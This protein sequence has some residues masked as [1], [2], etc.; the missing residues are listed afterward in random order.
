[1]LSFCILI[2]A[3]CN[4]E[5][6]IDDFLPE[7]PSIVIEE[8]GGRAGITFESDNWDIIYIGE[9]GI[10]EHFIQNEIRDL[11]GNL[12]QEYLP[13]EGYKLASVSCK[14]EFADFCVKREEPCSLE[15]S[16]GENMY[17]DPLNIQIIV[18]N[19]YE[20]KSISV[21]LGASARYRIDSVS[22]E[23]SGFHWYDNTLEPVD[24][25]TINNSSSAEPVTWIVYPY[26]DAHR[27]IEFRGNE[28]ENYGRWLGE[29]LPEIEI[30]DISDGKPVLA[31]TKAV[32]GMMDQELKTDLPEDLSEEVIIAPG[33]K[34]KVTVFLEM[35]IY[36]VPYKV[37][38]SSPA[39]GRKKV[40]SG[41]LYSDR[42]FGHFIL[43]QAADD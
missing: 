39:T 40:F 6:F 38:A 16:L 41:K 28:I 37:Y 5:A 24:E 34:R 11:D 10:G 12:L 30:P 4:T 14:T 23:F 32:F 15:V 3:G 19:G 43:K 2:L 29:S 20:T 22:Y 21:K 25:L 8:G 31:G 26:K 33:E 9:E 35:E 7:P 1:M 18:G 36:N 42:P 17:T 27:K 13:L